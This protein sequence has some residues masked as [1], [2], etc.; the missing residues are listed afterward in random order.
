MGRSGVKGGRKRTSSGSA[1]I[2][3]A[4]R[5]THASLLF[6]QDHDSLFFREFFSCALSVSVSTDFQF[7]CGTNRVSGQQVNMPPFIRES[8]LQGQDLE[9]F[10]FMRKHTRRS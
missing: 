5:R 8:S 3:T 10:R 7:K 6:S 1:V 2:G 9:R 4:N